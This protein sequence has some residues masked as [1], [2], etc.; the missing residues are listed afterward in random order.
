MKISKIAIRLISLMM[1]IVL[2]FSI[3]GLSAL[4]ADES[5]YV[6]EFSISTDKSSAEKDEEITVSVHLKT[7]YYICTMSLVILYDSTKLT[8]LGTSASNPSKFLNFKGQMADMYTTNG[9]WKSPETFYT[10]RNSNTGFWSQEEVMNRYKIVYATWSADTS[11]SYDL[12]MLSEEE[13]ILSFRVKAGEKLESLTD[14]IFIS[15]DFQKTSS[16]PQGLFFVGRSVTSEY[17][18]DSMV[19]TGQ[20]II[21]NGNDPT[22][23]GIVPSVTPK[24]GTGTVIDK[25]RGIIYGLEVGADSLDDFVDVEGYTVRYTYSGDFFGTGTRVDYIFCGVI[26]ETYYVVIFGDMTGDGEIDTY[27]VSTAFSVVNGDFEAEEIQAIAGDVYSDGT[28]DIY[29]I[30]VIAAVT[31]GDCVIPQNI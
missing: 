8:L 22:K 27:D 26:R 19:N 17:S 31:N 1:T 21:Y 3:S 24:E 20:T 12:A 13:E 23:A 29:D 11:L 9:N 15:H 10:K 4:G 25:E 16:S 2:L 18:S 6:A 28:V 5:D 30:S 7:D 14:L